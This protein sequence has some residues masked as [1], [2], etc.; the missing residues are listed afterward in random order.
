MPGKRPSRHTGC[1][2]G[3]VQLNASCVFWENS[4]KS[5]LQMTGMRT[6]RGRLRPARLDTPL[7]N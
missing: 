2:A 3:I 1:I 4:E 6:A 5:Q 7:G